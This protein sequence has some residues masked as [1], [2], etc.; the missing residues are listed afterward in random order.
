MGSNLVTGTVI[1]TLVAGIA[2]WITGQHRMP[3][4]A[5]R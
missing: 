1:G 3:V 5:G 2:Y 4:P